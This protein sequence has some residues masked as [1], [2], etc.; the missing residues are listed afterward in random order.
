MGVGVGM[1][2]GLG[3]AVLQSQPLTAPGAETVTRTPLG[4]VTGNGLT[5]SKTGVNV[6]A[7]S[8]LFVVVG[9]TMGS[10]LG[11]DSS[12]ITLDG[13]AVF[14]LAPIGVPPS[15]DLAES[16]GQSQASL[17][18]TR[19][20]TAI[21]DGTVL[22]E[23]IDGG[24]S[25]GD[26]P[27]AMLLFEVAG[28]AATDVLDQIHYGIGGPSGAPTSGATAVTAQDH[29]YVLGLV[30][31]DESFAL[32]PPAGTWGAPLENGQ[33]TGGALD[34]YHFTLSEGFYVQSTAAAQTAAKSGMDSV[35]WAAV[36][37][38]FRAA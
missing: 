8:Y 5:L 32:N 37:V 18:Y 10:E 14:S 7:G 15:D 26:A 19:C 36:V 3:M 29:E 13:N 2:T 38:T 33:R 12:C 27:T 21:V 35:Y 25:S 9:R 28:L 34:D 31:S 17:A 23:F 6:A 24:P 4:T 20:P 30:L 1:G 22:I 11:C 16:V